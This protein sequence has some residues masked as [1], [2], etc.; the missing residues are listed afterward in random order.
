MAKYFDA[1]LMA[2]IA[3]IFGGFYRHGSLL[4]EISN[5]FFFFSGSNE[6]TSLFG[7]NWD[8]YHRKE[9][10]GSLVVPWQ[11]YWDDLF[12]LI[13]SQWLPFEKLSLSQWYL[14]VIDQYGKGIGFA[15]GV[16]SQGIVGG[17]LLELFLRGLLTGFLFAKFHGWYVKRTHLLWA[18]VT[19]VF[20]AVKSYYIYRASTAYIFYFV[21]YHLIPTYLGI[22]G[23]MFLLTEAK[24]QKIEKLSYYSS[25]N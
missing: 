7:T 9:I 2:L 13:P 4:A 20:I 19:Y 14:Q 17:G 8:L 10:I 23:I 18:L 16:I 24:T 3:F 22:K 21:I 5:I 6:F 11:V 25:K 1:I 15:F 12:Y